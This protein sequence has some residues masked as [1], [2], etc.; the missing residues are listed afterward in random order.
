MKYL[1]DKTNIMEFAQFSAHTPNIN[2]QPYIREAQ[3]FDLKRAL[4]SP[5]YTT[6]MN[7][8]G[9]ETIDLTVVITAGAFAVNDV[10]DGKLGADVVATGKITAING[11]VYTIQP[12]TGDW[13]TA[14]SI[15]ATTNTATISSKEFGK[16]HKLFYGESYTD[17]CDYPVNYEGIIPSLVYWTYARYYSKSQG[18]ATPTGPAVKT[19]QFSTPEEGDSISMKVSAANSG[20]YSYFQNVKKYICDMNKTEDIYPYQEKV[21]KPEGGGMKM[22]TADRTRNRDY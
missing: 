4:G 6:L 3:E 9:T 10:I 21:K 2:Y 12:V 13:R 1:I 5:L 17:S 16:Y 8:L 18:V 20:A 22:Y 15:A 7:L 11:L 14:T 19:N